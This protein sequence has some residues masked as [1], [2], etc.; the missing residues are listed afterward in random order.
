M[1]QSCFDHFDNTHQACKGKMN[2]LDVFW[3]MIAYACT[4]MWAPL[5]AWCCVGKK[6][7]QFCL[8]VLWFMLLGWAG[9][10]WCFMWMWRVTID[11]WKG[12]GSSPSGIK[13]GKKSIIGAVTDAVD[14]AAD[15]VDEEVD[16]EDD[17]LMRKGLLKKMGGKSK[18]TVIYLP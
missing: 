16:E 14:D 3:L 7:G 8:L 1:C 17:I 12:D 2:K 18:K 4:G 15:A 10:T 9:H 13:K 5:W 6:C 11:A